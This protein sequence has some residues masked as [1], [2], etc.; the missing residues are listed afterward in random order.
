MEE[1]RAGATAAA[2]ASNL[3]SAFWARS[4]EASLEVRL[5]QANALQQTYSMN[6]EYLVT[7]SSEEVRS[8]RTPR[9]QTEAKEDI[10]CVE[11]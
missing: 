3:W 10:S 6:R 2:L 1:S 8:F 9:L 4:S 7:A 11:K 5:M